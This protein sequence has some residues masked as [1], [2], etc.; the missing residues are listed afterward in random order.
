MPTAYY[1]TYTQVR[2]DPA[3]S[4]FAWRL[5][6]EGRAR[7][8][9]VINA[10]WMSRIG[11]IATPDEARAIETA[12]ILARRR[13]LP[14]TVN[15]GLRDIGR[16]GDEFLGAAEHR[17]TVATLFARPDFGTRPGWET[18][19]HA[20]ARIVAAAKDEIAAGAGGGDLLF[21]GHGAAGTLLLCH[22]CGAPISLECFEPTPGGNLFAFDCRTLKVLF[23]WRAAV[24]TLRP[25]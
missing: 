22:L 3:V 21:T 11:R 13:S 9:R 8:I 15:P 16:P 24:P 10:P 2:V 14:V 12:D 6:D 25:E 19:C 23:R 5:S 1:F 7:V 20:Q 18:A 17:E 4:N